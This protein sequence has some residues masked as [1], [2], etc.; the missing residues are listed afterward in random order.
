V[1]KESRRAARSGQRSAAGAAGSRGPSGTPRAGRRERPRYRE[2]KTF[3]QRYRALLIG[4]AAVAVVVV[5]GGVIFT[6]ATSAAYVCTTEWSPAPTASPSPGQSNRIGYIQDYQGNTHNLPKPYKYTLCPPASGNHIN[7][8]GLGPIVPRL[9]KPND[10]IGPPNW[11]HNLEH[12]ALVVLYRGN[13]EGATDAGQQQLKAFFD[14]FP[15]SPICKEPKGILS[16]VI[17]RFDQMNWPYVAMVWERVLPL[18]TWDPAV[19]LQ[20]YATESE[21]LDATGVFVTP[22]EPQCSLPSA[23]P[24]ASESAAPS[25]SP[26]PSESSA[27]GAS[28]SASPSAASPEPSASPSPAPS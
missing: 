19:V 2:E 3:V 22:P 6:Q 1:S 25:A 10:T 14:A 15:P 12:G 4:L 16:P 5:V 9:F 28:G 11:I 17:S 8:T 24:G 18:D 27:P 13:G 20:F 21:R 26:A 7:A 23:S